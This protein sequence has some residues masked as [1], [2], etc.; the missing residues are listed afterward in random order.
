[1][2]KALNKIS[3]LNIKKVETS[4]KE[5]SQTTTNNIQPQKRKTLGEEKH[6]DYDN[7]KTNPKFKFTSVIPKRSVSG[8]F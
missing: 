1:M 2:Q 6:H 4:N 3:S 7:D 5:N 8:H